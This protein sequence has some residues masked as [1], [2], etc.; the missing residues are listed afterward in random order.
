MTIEK[1]RLVCGIMLEAELE[2][3]SETIT[4]FRWGF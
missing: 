4:E 3:E 1:I 2:M